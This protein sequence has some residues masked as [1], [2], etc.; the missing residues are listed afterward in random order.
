MGRGMSAVHVHLFTTHAPVWA[1]VLGLLLWALGLVW[2]G[3]DFRRPAWVLFVL[4]GLLCGPAYFSGAPARHALAAQTGWDW[5]VADQHEEVAL[6][7][8]GITLALTAMA[9]LALIRWRPGHQLPRGVQGVLLSLALLSAAVLV[10]TS[11]L[12]GRVRHVEIHQPGR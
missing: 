11:G 5:R 9:A 1:V 4:A 12:G 6:L 2:H 8:L 7:A 10:W 3:T